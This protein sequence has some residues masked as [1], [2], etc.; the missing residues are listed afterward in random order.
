[1]ALLNGIAFVP[2][3][4]VIRW[5]SGGAGWSGWGGVGTCRRVATKGIVRP[6]PVVLALRRGGVVG[7]LVRGTAAQSGVPRPVVRTVCVGRWTGRIARSP[8]GKAA[9]L[10][11]PP[12]SY[13]SGFSSLEIEE[14]DLNW[15]RPQSPLSARTNETDKTKRTMRV[16]NDIFE[17]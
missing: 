6:F 17:R 15:L 7:W 16:M 5:L 11:I 2:V 1:M 13:V 4:M 12:K 10:T 3:M 14:T 9:V 8:I